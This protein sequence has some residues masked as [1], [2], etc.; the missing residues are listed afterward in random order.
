[1]V[2]DGNAVPAGFA[3][4]ASD[5]ERV[6]DTV[7][8]DGLEQQIAAGSSLCL[9]HK[10]VPSIVFRVARNACRNP[11]LV[12]VVVSIPLVA[13]SDPAFLTPDEALATRRTHELVDVKLKRL[14]IRQVGRVKVNVIYKIMNIV[15]Q[16]L[17][18]IRQTLCRKG[19]Y[20]VVIP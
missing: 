13:T 6:S 3:R 17:V 19:P 11:F 4:G 10:V 12:D 20:K 2:V 8:G 9:N 16:P 18:G 5:V 1:M 14:G 15:G 7:Q